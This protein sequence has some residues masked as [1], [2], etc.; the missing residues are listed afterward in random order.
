MTEARVA[1]R[2]FSTLLCT[3]TQTQS[4]GDKTCN[5]LRRRS[6][7]LSV[8]DRRGG[9]DVQYSQCITLPFPE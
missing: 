2:N 7:A 3:Y 8:A 9:E 1:P 6:I 4:R 5:R